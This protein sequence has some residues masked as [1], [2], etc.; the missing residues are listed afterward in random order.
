MLYIVE[1]KMIITSLELKE[2]VKQ[3]ASPRSRISR[4]I[5]NKE[6]IQIRRGLY[7]DNTGVSKTAL[8]PLIYGPSYISFQWA[9]SHY[10]LIPEEVKVLTSAS[11][12]K[13]KNKTYKTPLGEFHYYYIPNKIYPYGL[14]MMQTENY[15]YLIASPEKAL[16]DSVYK[17]S[18]AINTNDM[19]MLLLDSWRMEK[20]D[21]LKLDKDFIQWIA[22][23][24]GK[25]SLL[26]LA[27]WFAVRGE[28]L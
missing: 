24:Y 25:K 11:F 5:K 3:Y 26:A 4:L 23:L 2:Q 17:I 28:M 15:S 20:E 7:V 27:K 21:L 8:A 18:Y 6:I 13:N 12:N 22:P 16:C 1:V 10:G 19:N 14:R 9:L